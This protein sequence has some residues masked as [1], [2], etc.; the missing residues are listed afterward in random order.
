MIPW[1]EGGPPVDDDALRSVELRLGMV[2]PAA[3]RDFYLR[4]NGGWADDDKIHPLGVHGYF[5]IDDSDTSV[6]GM[7]AALWAQS[8]RLAGSIPFAY[9]AGG[10]TYLV[11][12]ALV[13][14]TA[15]GAISDVRVRV[16]LQDGDEVVF[17]DN[18]LEDFLPRP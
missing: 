9:D 6:V 10:N 2:L 18:A 13:P 15:S 12:G 14:G 4:H 3:L 11:P 17:L 5:P 8:D 1:H 7:A 16:W